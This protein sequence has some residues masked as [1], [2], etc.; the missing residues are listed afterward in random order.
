MVCWAGTRRRKK[1]QNA[2]RDERRE[3]EQVRGK[4]RVFAK[5]Y[6]EQRVRVLVMNQRKGT[7]LQFPEY[8]FE[9]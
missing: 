6:R 2:K 9:P 5:E 1:L 3:R 4:E 7:A 8:I